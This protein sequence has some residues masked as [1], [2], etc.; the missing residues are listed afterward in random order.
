LKKL[1]RTKPTTLR[2]E[3]NVLLEEASVF[4]P[5]TSNFGSKIPDLWKILDLLRVL[6][7]FLES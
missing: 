1:F 2:L 3:V 4:L 5:E 6:G 7:A